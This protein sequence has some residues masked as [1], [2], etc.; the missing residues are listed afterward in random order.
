MLNISDNFIEVLFNKRTKPLSPRVIEQAKLS[1]LDY[2]AVTIAGYS[3]NIEK[4]NSYLKK[5]KMTS[6]DSKVLGSNNKTDIYSSIILNGINSHVLELDDGERRGMLHPGVPVISSLLSTAFTDNFSF[7]S[8][9]RGLLIGYDATILIAR[10][11]Q[12][13]LNDLGYHGTGVCGT[14]GSALSI[15]TL[16]NLTKS[17]MKHALSSSVTS[18]GGLLNAINDKSE[19]KPYNVAQASLNGYVSAKLAQ[20]GFIGP[21]DPL[22]GVNGFLPMMNKKYDLR[23]LFPSDEDFC[24]LDIYRK[25]YAACRHSHGAIDA[26]LKIKNKYKINYNDIESVTV[27]THK[28]AVELHDHRVIDSINSAKMSTP[29]SVAVALVKDNAGLEEFT[30]K[31]IRDSDV[32]NLSNKIKVIEDVKLTSL[33]PNKRA[34]MVEIKLNNGRSY[35]EMIDYPLGEPENTMSVSQLIRKS[36]NLLLFSGLNINRTNEIIDKTLNLE[37]NF[38]SLLEIL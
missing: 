35:Q 7:E 24:I 25:P 3:V 10:T 16:L 32:L 13:A 38:E 23:N 5:T 12:P 37:A 30:S 28:W 29:F 2:L 8:F 19:L 14:I 33:V 36:E 26:S 1:L 18:A 22:T 27:E 21:E 11:I 6:N 4:T 9:L 31:A 15:A 34:T 17:E 20:A